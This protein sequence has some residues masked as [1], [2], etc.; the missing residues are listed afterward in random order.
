VLFGDAEKDFYG[1]VI[2]PFAQVNKKLI[3]A[4]EEEL[5]E[6]PRARSGKLRIG[7]KL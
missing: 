7:I 2:R 4:S 1:N 5:K 6:N 3:E